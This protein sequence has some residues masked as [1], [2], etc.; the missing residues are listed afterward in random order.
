MATLI[1]NGTPKTL[2]DGEA[3][4]GVCEAEGLLFNCHT[5]ECASC[6]IEILDGAKN[7]SELT[8]EETRLGLDGNR[9]LACCCR[10]LKET[11][12]IGF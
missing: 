7:L 9:R 10:I 6:L 2:R 4:A 8:A 3:I 1:I 11:V 5:G 12:S